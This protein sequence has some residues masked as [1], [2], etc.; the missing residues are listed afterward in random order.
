MRPVDA[1]MRAVDDDEHFR[2]KIAAAAVEQDAGH[3]DIGNL[4][5]MLGAEK[6]QPG[7][8]VLSV[9]HQVFALRLA[10]MAYGF[11]VSRPLEAERL[12]R[13]NQNRP[14]NHRLCD[15][16]LIK[17]D[18][19]FHLL[20]VQL[21]LKSLLAPFNAGDELGD[22]V[23]LGDLRLSN[24]LTFKKIPA[25]KPHLVQEVDRIVGDEVKR[26]FLLTDARRKHGCPPLD[27]APH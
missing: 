4:I 14:G 21:A 11:R 2:R 3:L 26:A 8:P 19:L 10:E 9:D 12:V 25:R 6:M 1:S 27:N 17:I 23:M 15:D 24:L 5:R 13:K 20:P 18:D 7:Q 22:V 16:R